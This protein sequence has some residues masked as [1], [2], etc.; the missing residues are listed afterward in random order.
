MGNHEKAKDYYEKALILKPD[1]IPVLT[2][3]ANIEMDLGN[4]EKASKQLQEA[5]LL[6][7]TSKDK[8]NVY[9]NLASFCRVKGQMKKTLEYTQLGNK[10]LEEY[11]IP[12]LIV[13]SKIVSVV[14]YIRAGQEKEAFQR[15]A[16][17]ESALSPPLDKFTS[18]GYLLLYLELEKPGEAEQRLPG[19][20]DST[21]I[22]GNERLLYLL[23]SARGEIHE[24][25]GEYEEAI[26]SYE[27]SLKIT[28]TATHVLKQIG[29]CYRHLKHYKKAEE[30]IQKTLKIHPFDP[31]SN[32]EMAL[33]YLEMGDKKKALKRLTIASEVWKDADPDYK[34]AQLA[35][36]K[37][38]LL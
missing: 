19:V 12:L 36:E 30:Y 8:S 22:F 10:A 31:E 29:R 34:P 23:H 14:D 11:S 32:Y 18:I 13:L 28:P 17:L 37:L 33:V 2:T 27:A 21:N 4:F 9:S 20:Q 3:L 26:K 16:S 7:K 24:M 15:L 35:R 5:L 25:R 6:C 38:S 1:N